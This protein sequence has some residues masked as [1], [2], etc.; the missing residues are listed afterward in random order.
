M[1]V[2]SY[3]EIIAAMKKGE[4]HIVPFSKERLTPAGYD[5]ASDLKFDLAPKEQKLVMTSECIDLSASILATIHLKSS[6]T[7]E[8]MMGSFA[9]I[10]PG[11]RGKLTLCLH[12]SGKKVITVE[13]NESIVQLVFHRTGKPSAHPYEGKYQ[14]SFK[15]VKSLRS[16][17]SQKE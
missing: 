6:L 4:L 8:G 17:E 14:N 2:L 5:F 13:K 15:I 7:R 9:I 16:F 11:F 1:T 10:D 12:N 3:G